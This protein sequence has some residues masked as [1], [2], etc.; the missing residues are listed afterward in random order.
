MAPSTASVVQRAASSLRRLLLFLL[1]LALLAAVGWLLAERNARRYWLVPEGGRLAVYQGILFPVGKRPFGSA[2][3]VAAEAYA[4]IDAPPGAPV[5]GERAFGDRSELDQGLFEVLA[6]WARAD[7]QSDDPERLARGLGY[8]ARAEKLAGITGEQRDALRMLRAES[9]F[10]EARQLV[11]RAA[12]ALTDAREKLR[13]VTDSRSRKAADAFTL[14]RRL[15]PVLEEVYRIARAAEGADGRP[16]PEEAPAENA[17][18]PGPAG[19]AAG[20]P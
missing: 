3:P 20:A 7:I 14:L 5:P 15:E 12:E 8:L 16:S 10:H 17:P 1:V 9:G 18:A 4:P 13:L 6:G 19:N 11:A 2:D